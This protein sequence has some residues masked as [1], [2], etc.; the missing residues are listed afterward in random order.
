MGLGTGGPADATV[1]GGRQRGLAN[2]RD[3][4]AAHRPAR[5]QDR[6]DMVDQHTLLSSQ[7]RS[8]YLGI[9]QIPSVSLEA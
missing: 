2:I 1:L 4:C 8:L 3:I 9:Q 5:F 7:L 6:C